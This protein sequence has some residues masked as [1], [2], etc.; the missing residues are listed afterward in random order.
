MALTT[1]RKISGPI[2]DPTTLQHAHVQSQLKCTEEDV[3]IQNNNSAQFSFTHVHHDKDFPGSTKIPVRCYAT[4]SPTHMQ[5]FHTVTVY[6]SQTYLPLYIQQP[7]YTMT[8][9]QCILQNAKISIYKAVNSRAC[10][11]VC[12]RVRACVRACV[13]FGG[14]WPR[15]LQKINYTCLKPRLSR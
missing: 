13:C 12:V 10:V 2:S 1:H 4:V 8:L 3:C 9:V 5:P 11:R 14:T 7:F 6:S 15:K